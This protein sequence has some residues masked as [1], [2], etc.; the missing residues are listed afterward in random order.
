MVFQGSIT[1]IHLPTI[2][3]LFYFSNKSGLLEVDLDQMKYFIYFQNGYI[4]D[5]STNFINDSDLELL[6]IGRNLPFEK[7]KEIINSDK[8]HEDILKFYIEKKV[9]T[10]EDLAKMHKERLKL[11]ALEIS[12]VEK[13]QFIYKRLEEKEMSEHMKIK[14]DV[15]ALLMDSISYSEALNEFLKRYNL[16]SSVTKKDDHIPVNYAEYT[17][18]S[19]IK[20]GSKM[21]DILKKAK[22]TL[23]NTLKTV[24]SLEKKG[25]IA[26]QETT[27]NYDELKKEFP[28]EVEALIGDS[29]HFKEGYNYLKEHLY[30]QALEEFK[31]T[32]ALFS[33]RKV[34]FYYIA[35]CHIYLAQL[36]EALDIVKKLLEE[37]PSEA[38]NYLLLSRILFRIKKDDNALKYIDE[39]LKR[40]P[41]NTLLLLEKASYHYRQR[42]MKNAQETYKKV[43]EIDPRDTAVYLKLGAIYLKEGNKTLAREAWQKTLEIE[44]GNNIAK[45]NLESIKE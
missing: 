17:V 41:R 25:A 23:L 45:R 16:R 1:T 39:G 3:Q 5:I 4:A 20:E 21:A 31:K 15:Q 13:G 44:P 2:Y 34:I 30:T 24:E 8:K 6:L 37:E 36:K 22:Y 12:G 11:L 28:Q 26:F 38:F 27:E 35:V 29:E 32:L 9:I 18:L 14:L 42:D 33:D 19:E 7:I 40:S 10:Q 43:L